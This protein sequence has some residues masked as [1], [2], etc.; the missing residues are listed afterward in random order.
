[1]V[2]ASS[3]DRDVLQGYTEVTCDGDRLFC[4]P[5]HSTFWSAFERQAWEP[6]TLG[7]LR[8][9][10]NSESVY[11]DIGSWIGPTV[12]FAAKRCRSVFAFEPDPHA[13]PSLL[14]NITNNR[15]TNVRAFNL[16]VAAAPGVGMLSSFGASL[17][18]SMSS[19]LPQAPQASG[20]PVTKVTMDTLINDLSCAPPDFVKMDIEGGEFDLIPAL[21]DHLERWRPVLYLSLHAP[22]LPAPERAEKLRALAS[23]LDFYPTVIDALEVSNGSSAATLRLED[24]PESSYRDDFGTLLLLPTRESSPA[25]V[26]AP[27][28]PA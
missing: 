23:A 17:G 14:A 13:Y 22:Y 18:D 8:R 2:R 5:H 21:R 6:E 20:W 24:L 1:M 4:D 16:A 11:Y 15:L 27:R 9:F 10:L 19:L 12:V 7:V 3:S 26:R 28:V 25:G